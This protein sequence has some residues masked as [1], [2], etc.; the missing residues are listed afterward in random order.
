LRRQ[1]ALSPLL[2]RAACA[3]SHSASTRARWSSVRA[4]SALLSS[5]SGNDA[6]SLSTF[7]ISSVVSRSARR[8]VRR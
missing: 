4:R 7:L 5:S 1:A 8:P 3:S 2:S 6:N